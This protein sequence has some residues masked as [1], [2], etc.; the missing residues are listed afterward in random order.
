[1][2]VFVFD[3]LHYLVTEFFHF[4]LGLF[5]VDTFCGI[6]RKFPEFLLLNG[7]QLHVLE[8]GHEVLDVVDPLLFGWCLDFLEDILVL[9]L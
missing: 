2:F 4:L 6:F 1:M 5:I 9:I 3:S 7:R 8:K